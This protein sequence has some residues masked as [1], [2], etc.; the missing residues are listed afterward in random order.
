VSTI[1]LITLG[2]E[3]PGMTPWALGAVVPVERVSPAVLAHTVGARRLP[4]VVAE[5]PKDG[6]PTVGHE[7]LEIAP[8]LFA[9]GWLADVLGW[10][11][12]GIR[13]LCEEEPNVVAGRLA[14]VEVFGRLYGA[15]QTPAE[16]T[17]LLCRHVRI[18][19]EA[20]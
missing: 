18:V 20:R 11:T 7:Q 19:D 15:G 1:D 8:E 9:D 5:R 2:S 4:R 13:H 14:S 17:D 3:P 6:F 10:S 12:N 16:V